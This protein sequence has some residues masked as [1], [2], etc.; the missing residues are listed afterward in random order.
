MT[1]H[2]ELS[3]AGPFGAPVI[4]ALHA[5]CFDDEPWS[6]QDVAELLATPG[7]IAVLA[8]DGGEPL[9]FALARAAAE[10]CEL[11]SIGVLQAAR[12][13]GIGRHLL[14]AVF[15]RAAAAGAAR[16]FLE[17]AEDNLAARALY[18]QEGFTRIGQRKGYYRRPSG[19]AGDA[20]VLARRLWA[21]GPAENP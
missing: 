20:V 14:H 13:G 12:R 19:P 2:L 18:G 9:G 10:D 4:A 17:V 8:Q 3:D 1:A 7:A 16:L 5:A 15:H 21:V 11:L 6:E